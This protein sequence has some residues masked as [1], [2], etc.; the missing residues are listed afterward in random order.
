M[1]RA[2]TCACILAAGS[3]LRL[4]E[5]GQGQP[6]AFIRLGARPIIEESIERLRRS[7]IERIV[8]VTG[9]GA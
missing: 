6:K 3:G 9:Y 8:I 7:G 4:G 2:L 1:S 5:G